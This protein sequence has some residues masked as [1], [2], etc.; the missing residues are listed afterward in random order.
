MFRGA[1]Q[2]LG[3]K[4]KACHPKKQKFTFGYL[5][6]LKD[7]YLQKKQQK[8]M[9]KTSKKTISSKQLAK[10]ISKRVGVSLDI[11]LKNV[12]SFINIKTKKLSFK[13]HQRHI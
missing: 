9:W 5:I 3:Y 7:H 12:F 4:N 13:K 11:K 8:Q 2:F 6:T 1:K 10:Q